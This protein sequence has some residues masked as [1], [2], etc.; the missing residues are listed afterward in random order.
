M[1]SFQWIHG[2]TTK[3]NLGAYPL[4]LG[5]PWLATIDAY[6]DCQ[7]GNMRISHGN[8]VKELRLYPLAKT[9]IQQDISLWSTEEEFEQTYKALQLYMIEEYLATKQPTED[10]LIN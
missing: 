7:S 9:T 4:I 6:I 10:D 2:N 3:S 8:F 1:L 5:R